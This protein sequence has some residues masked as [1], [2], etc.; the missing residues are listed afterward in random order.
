MFL[1]WNKEAIVRHIER[2]S[3]IWQDNKSYM[4]VGVMQVRVPVCGLLPELSS[5]LT[6]TCIEIVDPEPSWG[7][8]AAVIFFHFIQRLNYHHYL[9]EFLMSGA[10]YKRGPP[11]R[12]R[13]FHREHRGGISMFF[14]FKACKGAALGFC[15]GFDQLIA[16][17]PQLW[18]FSIRR[19]PPPGRPPSEGGGK[20]GQFSYRLAMEKK[21]ATVFP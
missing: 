21:R 10:S 8:G 9:Q 17:Y 11:G 19:R 6:L 1:S 3:V 4:F 7:D 16:F 2:Y 18:T 13:D 20:N 5:S 14:G 15:G 12:T